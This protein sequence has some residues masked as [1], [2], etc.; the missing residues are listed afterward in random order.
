MRRMRVIRRLFLLLVLVFALLVAGVQLLPH[1]TGDLDTLLPDADN[2][3][4]PCALGIIP[5]VTS[6]DEAGRILNDH[7]WVADYQLSRSITVDS[8]YLIWR[9]SGEQPTYID[10]DEEAALWVDNGRVEWMQVTT[11]LPFGDLWLRLGTPS[12]GYV[13]YVELTAERIF[14]R[15]YYKAY[16]LLVEFDVLCPTRLDGFWSAPVRLRYG[17]QP[18]DDA[19]A[20]QTPRWGACR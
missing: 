11:H 19:Q 15:M 5:G 8:G 14:Q 18:A 6:L 1:E 17:V 16:D 20:Y 10:G 7:P 4:L 12:G 9:W 13:W 2:C 3:A